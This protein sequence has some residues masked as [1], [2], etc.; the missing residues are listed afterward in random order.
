[1]QYYYVG[2]NATYTESTG[3]IQ[4]PNYPGSYDRNLSCYYVIQASPGKKIE[5]N[6]IELRLRSYSGGDSVVVSSI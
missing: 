1:M 2:C 4:S 6:F 3:V 5:L